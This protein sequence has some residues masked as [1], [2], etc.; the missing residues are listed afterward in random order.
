MQKSFDILERK[1]INENNQLMIAELNVNRG[2]DLFWQGNI[3]DAKQKFKDAINIFE[4]VRIHELS[5]ALNNYANCQMMQGDFDNAISSLRRAIMFN[6]SKYTDIVLK[7]HLMV[8]Y[9]ISGN[10]NYL[11]LFGE[12]EQFII[13]NRNSKLDI[14]VYLK[15]IYSLG[16]IQE[17]CGNECEEKLSKCS[18]NYTTCAI[19][20]LNNYDHDTLPYIWFKDWNQNVEKDIAQKLNHDD[21]MNFFNYR[22]EPW[23]LTITHD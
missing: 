12:L 19:G 15:V 2:F 17:V 18:V 9:A 20:L 4:R 11:R 5:Y 7:T 3:N 21:Y 23:L 16:F 10:K 14:S 6:K 1:Y 22:F 8:C 13:D